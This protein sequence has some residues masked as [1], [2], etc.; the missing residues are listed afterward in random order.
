MTVE[1]PKKKRLIGIVKSD[2]ML[3]SRRVEVERLFQHPKYTKIL[4]SRIVCHVHDEN[5]DSKVGDTVEIIECRPRSKTKRWE[6][7]RVVKRGLN[8]SRAASSEA[9]KS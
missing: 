3:K 9:A 8:V 7:L 6:L 1:Q 4:R 2:K 5:N